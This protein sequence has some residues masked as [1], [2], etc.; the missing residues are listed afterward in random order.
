MIPEDH[1]SQVKWPKGEDKGLGVQLRAGALDWDAGGPRLDS[2]HSGWVGQG[3]GW[4]WME[5]ILI[6]LWPNMSESL[7]SPYLAWVR[8]DYS[9]RQENLQV[10]AIFCYVGP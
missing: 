7:E 2:K 4:R 3:A 8:V 10:K 6:G 1:S 9:F 5:R